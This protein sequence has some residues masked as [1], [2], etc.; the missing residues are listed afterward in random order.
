MAATSG[1]GKSLADWITRVIEL[2][3]DGLEVEYKGDYEEI[4]V[5]KGDLGVGIG[6]IK[7]DSREAAA[8]R[9]ELWS[10]RNRTKRIAV[11]GTVYKARVSTFDSFGETAY[12]I[13]ILNPRK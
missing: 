4:T 10:L 5:M 8:L 7:S 11:R 3:G 2:G 6:E 9:D 12:R 1:S 13:E